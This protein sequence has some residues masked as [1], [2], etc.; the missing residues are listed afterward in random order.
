MERRT[1]RVLGALV[2]AVSLLVG[3]VAA[4]DRLAQP[5]QSGG[6]HGSPQLIKTFESRR[7]PVSLHRLPWPGRP[8]RGSPPGPLRQVGDNEESRTAA[9]PI[10][11]RTHR[12]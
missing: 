8:H 6:H 11:L 3:G 7:R 9:L 1:W 12:A 4:W 10:L 2:L 5:S